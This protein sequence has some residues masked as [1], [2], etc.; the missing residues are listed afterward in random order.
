MEPLSALDNL[1]VAALTVVRLRILSD[2]DTDTFGDEY[3]E[4]VE[5]LR[6]T[7]QEF[8]DSVVVLDD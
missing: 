3:D 4:A 7:A 1:I 5:D 6:V 2:A 8:V